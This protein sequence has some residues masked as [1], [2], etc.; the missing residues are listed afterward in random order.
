M[1][2]S[3]SDPRG[4][5]A[6]RSFAVQG[7]FSP[8]RLEKLVLS[9]I[10]NPFAKVKLDPVQDARYRGGV[11]AEELVRAA[12]SELDP[13]K[14]KAFLLSI[15][16]GLRRNEVDKREWG[17]FDFE[18]GTIHIG[19]TKYLHPKSEKSIGTV[20]LDRRF[21]R[22][23]A[24]GTRGEAQPSSLKAISCLGSGHGTR[25]TGAKGRSTS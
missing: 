12:V 14:L 1:I 4:Q 9:D 7:V 13:E 3:G 2:L 17:A 22:S 11:D 20:D 10:Q 15:G 25:I 8:E 16:A 21:W 19:P 6:I 23:S 24:V 18:A 5:R